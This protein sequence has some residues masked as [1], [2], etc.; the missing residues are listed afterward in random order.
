M[1]KY[2]LHKLT[3]YF[4]KLVLLSLII[5]IIDNYSFCQHSET[6]KPYVQ[7]ISPREYGY[8]SQN[9]SVT[10][11][12]RF[13][14]YFGNMNGILEF[15]GV[16]W[17]LINMKG[18]P[19]L[20]V[21]RHGRVYAGGRN[22]FGYL[23]Y[24]SK[25]NTFL[26]SL[27]TRIEPPLR[28]FG[29]I[30]KIICINKEVLFSTAD[31]LYR[32]SDDVF[33]VIS[34]I[35][36]TYSLLK[37]SNSDGK[38]SNPRVFLNNPEKGLMIYDQ[39]HFNL[40]VNGDKFKGKQISEILPSGDDE[41]LIKIKGQKSLVQFSRNKF[42]II[43][44]DVDE[45]IEK[46]ELV[47]GLYLSGGYY[48]LG[49]KRGGIVFIDALGHLIS[50]LNKQNGLYDDAVTSMF[51]DQAG[52]LWVTLN[53]GIS[54]I[55]YLSRFTF[56]DKN[57]GIKGSISSIIRWHDNIFI[58]TNHGVSVHSDENIYDLSG[59]TFRNEKTFKAVSGINA[60]CYHFYIISDQL[61]IT[62]SKGIFQ[63]DQKKVRQVYGKKVRSILAS[64]LFPGII[65]SVDD[66]G[67]QAFR[68]LGTKWETLGRLRGVNCE[69]RT[70]AET[71]NG[72]LWLGTDY[73][74]VFRV[75]CSRGYQINNTVRQ[76][77]NSAG[78]P[79][80]EHGND[81]YR[82]SSGVIFSTPKGLYTYDENKAWFFPDSL[83]NPEQ[84]NLDYR[85][86]P[87]A[88]DSRKNIWFSYAM[89]YKYDKKT[90][91][92]EYAGTG[93]K[94]KIITLPE[95]KLKDFSVET[96]FPDS[97]IVWFG[98]D[99]GLVRLDYQQM[100]K[101]TNLDI[102]CFISR[103]V[104]SKDSSFFSNAV[105]L[106][107]LGDNIINNYKSVV[108][109]THNLSSILFE[110]AA[111]YYESENDIQYQYLLENYDKSWSD[112]STRNV[113]EYTSLSEGKYV[114]RVKASDIYGQLTDE[115]VF[116]FIIKPPYY[117][118]IWAYLIYLI[119]LISFVLMVIKI[120]TYQFAK[121]K[122]NLETIIRERTEELLK[123]NER[124]E[125]LLVN[126]LPN[127]TAQ[128]LKL[129]GKASTIKFDLVTVLFSDIQG[130]TKI[131]QELNPDILVERLDELF[132]QFDLIIE[133][134]NIEKIKTIGDGYMCAGGVPEKNSTN[135]VDIV[136]A[137]LELQIFVRTFSFDDKGKFQGW[138]LRIG[139]HSG[140]VIAGVIGRKKYLYDI[141][142]VTVN[143]A[144]RMES[145]CESGEIN[146]SDST[147]ELVKNY[148][149][150]EPRGKIS[151][152]YKGFIDMYF[153]KGIRPDLIDS[154][155]GPIAPNQ[156]FNTMMAMLRFE[157]LKEKMLEKMRKEL[158]ENLYYHSV[159]HTI[160]VG[161]QVEYIG[162]AENISEEDK[163]ILKTAALF[164]D[165]GFSIAYDKHEIFG[166]KMAG[167]ILPA[168]QYTKEQISKIG[169]LIMSTRFP[170]KPVNKL[171]Q[172]L[173]D[174]DLD[175]LGREDF[176]VHSK[177]LFL[178]LSERKKVK[179]LEE[180][181][182]TQIKFIEKHSYHT[183]TA[184]RLRDQAKKE[185]L[186]KLR[187]SEG[188]II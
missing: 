40:M 132:Y 61:Y 142:G 89:S 9:F 116:H 91:I 140:S 27:Y 155:L 76:Y 174:S 145:L 41:F 57:Y 82:T 49:T 179:S 74:G 66:N 177:N 105:I 120:R 181:N 172:I 161:I 182:K 126:M 127:Q 3:N 51:I 2:Y 150:C 112:W 169:E 167:E 110:F 122:A 58:A 52:N 31:R 92:A 87:L 33:E 25:N 16:N 171:E 46:N 99:E 113:K 137:A 143:T 5:C 28:N 154:G 125:D 67:L 183:E 43:H 185:H 55:E 184:R 37:V 186:E 59:N 107:V 84:K 35:D 148:F 44:T 158:P 23:D 65:Y 53:N 34:K 121:V 47:C 54:R 159:E 101:D 32:Y 95:V 88:E 135:P 81:V 77:M 70:I 10:Q 134:Y 168:Y 130:F 157:D 17:K 86:F 147:Y 176:E 156:K 48:A 50:N 170:P 64:R 73:N 178:E 131:S 63:A 19:V 45:F 94:Y 15:N 97:Q 4:N 115:A 175:Y 69:V 104:T 123:E 78:L 60:E 42:N 146:I 118:S 108:T 128:E 1:T 124:A 144:N 75:D 136:L 188:N 164:H 187:K 119:L 90:G 103:I 7:N 14:L 79:S 162:E 93:K 29:Q 100:R 149:I 129:K 12:A 117:R 163:L 20:D 152:K 68:L 141:Y 24:Y 8:E 13:I 18:H 36:S 151:V 30:D 98:G 180:W 72:N 166:V 139:V 85:I 138:G 11:D 102:P 83:L 133:K 96:I 111:P 80:D 26:N 153:V 106:N 38:N 165:M 109:L 39:G 21:D 56:F 22:E 160:D 114:F 6:G 71:S 173:C 62:S